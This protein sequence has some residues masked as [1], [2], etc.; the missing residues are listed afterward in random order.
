MAKR[1]RVG[2]Q[3]ARTTAAPEAAPTARIRRVKSGDAEW[4]VLQPRMQALALAL[5]FQLDASEWWAPERLL[6]RQLGQVQRLVRHASRTVPFYRSR[7]RGV[8]ALASAGL[9]VERFREIPLLTRRDIQ[10]AGPALRSGRLPPEDGTPKPVKTSG[11][12]G[13]P[14]EVLATFRTDLFIH[15]F[16]MRGHRWHRR[17]LAAK[18][19]D[20]RT[21]FDSD[22]TPGTGRWAPLPRT[23]PGVR[24]DLALPI[25]GLLE[26]LLDEDPAYL[27]T[28]PYTLLGLVERSV[29]TGRR[30]AALREVRTFGEVL[31]PEI[32]A[33]VAAHWGVPVIDSYSAIEMGTL[34]HQ[35]PAS[36]LLH[37]QG[38][39]VLLEVLDD[40]GAPCGPGE[41]GRVVVTALHNFAT[42]LIRYVLGDYAE[43]GPACDC[44]RGLPA[45]TRI[46][47][48]EKSL[49]AYPSGE[50]QFPDPLLH[51]L[52]PEIP[53]RQYQLVQS[54]LQQIE[55]N[56]A[57]GRPL[58]GA[59]EATIR[60]VLVERLKYPFDFELNYMDEIPRSASG[61]FE[62]FRSD[63]E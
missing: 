22:E 39:G 54:T 40:D 48:R 37:V 49:L 41:V 19:V 55:V 6:H 62:A 10:D 4:P 18:N 47:G 51:T 5:Q 60:E 20:I 7:L 24:L 27:Q 9:T 29:E 44:G 1:P 31:R 16:T 17:D 61:K 36:E 34:A 26:A 43:V 50:R 56:L 2:Q 23:G 63:V 52:R 45:L 46:M 53:I 59:E 57:V 13:E 8:A 11:S 58:T 15:A 3:R 42:P 33:A 30:P 14:I 25:S 35:C 28:R 12:T 38:E 21:W 32:R